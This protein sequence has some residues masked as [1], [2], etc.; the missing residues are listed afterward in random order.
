VTIPSTTYC[1]GLTGSIGMGK[2]TTAGFFRD[3]GTPVWDADATVRRLYACGGAGVTPVQSIAPSA[4]IDNQVD[5][6]R[7]RKVLAENAELFPKLETLIHPLVAADRQA[8]LDKHL[9]K[10]VV[11]DVPL[12]YETNGEVWCDAVVV[13]TAPP[14]VQ[15]DRF[16]ARPGM[17][18]ETFHQILSR[19]IPDAEKRARADFVIDTS[20]GL[21][22]ARTAVQDILKT[23]RAGGSH[24]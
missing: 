13:V 3:E 8:F 12:L 16:L 11:L 24:A 15:R 17:T 7:L 21:E 4:I 18:D 10:I 1:L 20:L 23:V 9:G 2:S 6:A 14:Q 5:R 22:H 19:Q